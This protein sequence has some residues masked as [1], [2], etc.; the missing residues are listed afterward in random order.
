MV[1]VYSARLFVK[2]IINLANRKLLLSCHNF[3]KMRL[4][5][6]RL[7]LAVALCL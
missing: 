2:S 1:I 3:Q 6:K 5:R 4:F 7:E